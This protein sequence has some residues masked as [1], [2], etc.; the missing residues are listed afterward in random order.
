MPADLP[1]FTGQ[2]PVEIPAKTSFDRLEILIWIAE[3]E[4]LGEIDVVVF[5]Q[6]TSRMRCF[7]NDIVAKYTLF[8]EDS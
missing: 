4:E 8:C 1:R 2:R 6:P 3:I 7:G 5:P